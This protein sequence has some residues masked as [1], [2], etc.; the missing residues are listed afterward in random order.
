MKFTYRIVL[1]PDSGVTPAQMAEDAEELR[2]LIRSRWGSRAPEILFVHNDTKY[3]TRWYPVK[4][5]KE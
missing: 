1:E 4:E 3:T 5:V 2:V